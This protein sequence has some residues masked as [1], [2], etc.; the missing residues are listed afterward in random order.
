MQ[1]YVH[2]KWKWP[3]NS[4]KVF[5]PSANELTIDQINPHNPSSQFWFPVLEDRWQ[6]H[7]TTRQLRTLE[8]AEDPVHLN[9]LETSQSSSPY[10]VQDDIGR[11]NTND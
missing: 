2:L 7:L 1:I 10:F 3:I 9:E 5:V 6:D 11:R 4:K 8:R